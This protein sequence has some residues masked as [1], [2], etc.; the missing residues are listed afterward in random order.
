MKTKHD[1]GRETDCLTDRSTDGH[2][3]YLLFSLGTSWDL[4]VH[5][6]QSPF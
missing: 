5:T 6:T 4:H 1:A 3:P 2:I